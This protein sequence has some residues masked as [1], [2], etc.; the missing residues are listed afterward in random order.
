MFPGQMP[1]VRRDIHNIIVPLDFTDTKDI[2]LI[3]ETLQTF[4]ERRI[5]VRFGIVP[6]LPTPEA[7]KNAKALYYLY[8]RY[9]I[10]AL[11]GYLVIVGY[12]CTGLSGVIKLTF[13][14]LY[15]MLSRTCS[16]TK[17]NLRSSQIR[18]RLW[19]TRLFLSLQ[20]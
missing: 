20:L 7:E 12:A 18:P 1:Q 9:G 6:V 17:R 8:E 3:L 16:I 10:D 4:V 2:Q 19:K 11:L 15:Q 5:P 14:S 13:N